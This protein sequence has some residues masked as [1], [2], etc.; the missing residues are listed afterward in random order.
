MTLLK[1]AFG[2]SHW[3]SL[4]QH[5]SYSWLGEVA[6]RALDCCLDLKSQEQLFFYPVALKGDLKFLGQSL[7]LV[8]HPGREQD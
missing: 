1:M 6:A 7:N 2:M 3:G 4:C 5:M 8:R